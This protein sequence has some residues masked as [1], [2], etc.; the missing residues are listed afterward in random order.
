MGLNRGTLDGMAYL[1]MVDKG[2]YEAIKWINENI[3]GS[4][5]ILE[6]PGGYFYYASRI[7][8]FTG[9]PTVIGHDLCEITWGRAWDEVGE[10]KGDADAIYTTANNSEALELL[11]KYDV[12]YIY[13]G[14]GEREY[15]GD[16]GLQKFTVHT[17]DYD[18][19]Y[20]D[21]GVTIYEVRE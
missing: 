1:E 13:I 12:E 5:V 8:V 17:E 7:S 20:E 16:E 2:D 10:R 6:T 4:P 18:P 11:K 21:E 14:A 9:L 3:D 19:I 15:Y